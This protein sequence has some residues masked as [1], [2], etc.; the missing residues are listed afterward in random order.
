MGDN[1]CKLFELI[2]FSFKINCDSLQFCILLKNFFLD[3]F[4][5]CDISKLRYPNVPVLGKEYFFH[6]LQE[7]NA[8]HPYV[9]PLHHMV[10]RNPTKYFSLP[11]IYIQEQLD[12][13]HHG[14]LIPP[15]YIR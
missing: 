3:Q 1:L 12:S 13:N 7:N 4:T 14:Q 2:V 10:F 9:F 15:G 11:L 5:G 8:T 6:G